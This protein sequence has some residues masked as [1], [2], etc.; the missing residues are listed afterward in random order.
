MTLL[1]ELMSSSAGTQVQS[2]AKLI[3]YATDKDYLEA[4]VTLFDTLVGTLNLKFGKVVIAKSGKSTFVNNTYKTSMK[5]FQSA[6]NTC[7]NEESSKCLTQVED[8]FKAYIEELSSHPVH[9][10]NKEG[11]F[12]PSSLVPFCGFGADMFSF[13]EIVDNFT[14]PICTAF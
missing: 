5:P 10:R 9:I 6:V 8:V 13:G 3:E 2:T 14:Y 1:T 12:M 4:L 7:V 11:N